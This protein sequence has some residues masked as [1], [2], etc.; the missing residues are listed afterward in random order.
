[1]RVRLDDMRAQAACIHGQVNRQ[2]VGE[3]RRVRIS[4]MLILGSKRVARAEALLAQR[5]AERA[6]ALVARVVQEHNREFVALLNRRDDLV[7][8]HEVGAVTHHDVDLALW[9]GHLHAQC[10]RNF[11]AHG[12]VAVLEVILA[13]VTGAP[14]LVQ[15]ARQAARGADHHRLGV[16]VFVDGADD[17]ALAGQGRGAQG[18]DAVDLGLPGVVQGGGALRVVMRSPIVSQ[19]LRKFCEGRAG[20]AHQRQR[21]VLE[22]VKLRHIDVNEAHVWVRKEGFAR[23]R[24]VAVA[25]ANSDHQIGVAR[26]FC[27]GGGAGGADSAK[28]EGVVE[29]QRALARHCLGYGNAR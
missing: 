6:D 12:G 20:V 10:A 19:R 1:M 21:S 5:A 26:N 7:G 23:R 28:A 17:L 25:R 15:V 13:R 16:A 9:L 11:V 2:C 27:C 4:H 29:A 3:L 14:E 22:G 18:E 24:E 8:E